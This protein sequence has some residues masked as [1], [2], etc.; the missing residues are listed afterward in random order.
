MPDANE[1]HSHDCL[2]TE[3]WTDSGD[4][5]HLRSGSRERLPAH[6]ALIMASGEAAA[7]EDSP[8]RCLSD[9]LNVNKQLLVFQ[10]LKRWKFLYLMD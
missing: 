8:C 2:T 1:F 6:E 4:F 10:V 5:L 3:H 9:Q 7:G